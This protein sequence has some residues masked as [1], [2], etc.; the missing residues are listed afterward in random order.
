MSEESQIQFL[1]LQQLDR[2]HSYD[3]TQ[4]LTFFVIGIEIVFCGYVLLI[5]DKLIGVSNISLLFLT[6]GTAA[7][8]GIIWRFCYN[9]TYHDRVHGTEGKYFK[10]WGIVQLVFYYAYIIFTAVFFICLLIIGF[11]LLKEKESAKPSLPLI[12]EQTISRAIDEMDQIATSLKQIA[13]NK[14]FQIDVTINESKNVPDSNNQ[15]QVNNMKK[16]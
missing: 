13:D 3:L 15:E 6:S 7:I 16:P 2:H 5:S 12:S 9:Q 11:S 10:L 4:R 14:A 8:F 1:S